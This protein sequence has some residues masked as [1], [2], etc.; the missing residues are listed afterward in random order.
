[1]CGDNLGSELNCNWGQVR[2][3]KGDK[4][5][6]RERERERK[7][8]RE[9]ERERE[10][11]REREEVHGMIVVVAWGGQGLRGERERPGKK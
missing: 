9:R 4:G 5:D 7:R 2:K 6:E 3:R 10:K 11:E 1:M 8:A